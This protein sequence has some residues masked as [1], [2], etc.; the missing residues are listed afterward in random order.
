MRV[1]P[2]GIQLQR[3]SV[4]L[5]GRG[6]LAG[7]VQND[8]MPV[9]RQPVVRIPVNPDEGPAIG[10]GEEVGLYVANDKGFQNI[11]VILMAFSKNRFQL[12]CDVGKVADPLGFNERVLQLDLLRHPILLF[13]FE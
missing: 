1:L 7:G 13:G 5:L 3:F 2:I 11:T 4:F 6:E 12:L 8:S 10:L 9:P